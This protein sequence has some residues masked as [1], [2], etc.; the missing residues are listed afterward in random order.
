MWQ[1][2]KDHLLFT[3]EE[4]FLVRQSENGVAGD[5]AELRFV[6]IA[7]RQVHWE[8]ISFAVSHQLVLTPSVR[9]EQ[10]SVEAVEVLFAPDSANVRGIDRPGRERCWN[11][12]ISWDWRTGNRV[13]WL[14]VHLCTNRQKE[15]WKQ[16]E[17]DINHGARYEM[18]DIMLRQ[19]EF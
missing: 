18:V 12:K 14:W 13:S 6:V 11:E 19:N 3:V 2:R 15:E 4:S 16:L 9:R 17:G 8:W 7:V 1:S 5:N 10:R